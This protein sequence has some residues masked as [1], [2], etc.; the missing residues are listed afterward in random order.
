MKTT[1]MEETTSAWPFTDRQTR[2]NFRLYIFVYKKKLIILRGDSSSSNSG[3]WRCV[4]LKINKISNELI[5][6]MGQ[7][8][9][10]PQALTG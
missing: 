5:E 8:V 6:T 3:S 4:H 2:S 7:T 1:I 9:E 10:K